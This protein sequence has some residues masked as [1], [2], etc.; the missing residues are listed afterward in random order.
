MD[1]AER[2]SAIAEVMSI[3]VCNSMNVLNMM[4]VAR[5]CIHRRL[6]LADHGHVKLDRPNLS[7]RLS[8]TDTI[9]TTIS[10]RNRHE[11]GDFAIKRKSIYAN[12]RVSGF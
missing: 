5:N 7:S 1:E 9:T 6:L 11:L 4:V 12:S 2:I 10:Y 8:R 3:Y